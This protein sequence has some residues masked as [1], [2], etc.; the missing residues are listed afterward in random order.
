MGAGW[1]MTWTACRNLSRSG[2]RFESLQHAS[3][4]IGDQIH[5]YNHRRPHQALNMKTP[6]EAFA[7]AA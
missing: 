4:L 5:F 3:R 7:L 6:A 1:T 2:H